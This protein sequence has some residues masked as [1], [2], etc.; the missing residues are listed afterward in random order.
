MS[1]LR[2]AYAVLEPVARRTFLAAVSYDVFRP[3]RMRLVLRIVPLATANARTSLMAA[4]PVT[5]SQV[6]ARALGA[7]APWPAAR[8]EGAALAIVRA[9]HQGAF[10]DPA[11][12]RDP[13]RAV[14]RAVLH[15][16]RSGRLAQGAGGYVPTSRRDD[17][18][19]PHVADMFALQA[20]QLDGPCALWP[21]GRLGRS[22]SAEDAGC[23]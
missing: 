18:R 8:L 5:A 6:L 23:A 10:L 20:A 11:L 7:P 19:F 15:L 2:A 16:V 17:P 22:T 21:Q 14:R 9:L 3:G 13:R 4:R 12:S 1:R